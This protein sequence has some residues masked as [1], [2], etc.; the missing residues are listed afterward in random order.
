MARTERE[1]LCD[2]ALQVGETEPT[3]CEGWTVKD[4]VVHLLVRESSPA[5]IGVVVP[6]L[7]RWTDLASRRLA[8]RDFADL[9]E[10]LRGG[11]PFYSVFALPRMDAMLNTLEF[12]IHHEDI[13]RAQPRWKPRE[14]S[15]REQA[16][17]WRAAS[18]GGKSLVRG[19]RVGVTVERSD[20]GTQAVLKPGRS[21]VVVR[22]LPGEVALFVYGRK[23]HAD[24]ELSG[25]PADVAHLKGTS[26]GV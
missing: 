10:R 18:V 19:S 17:L 14:L 7:S 11:P 8:T 13:R 1:A 12:F 5:A 15:A 24:V 3:L 16:L 25:S 2:L 23:K 4:L 20:T 9:V 6:P 22:G 26:L 21:T